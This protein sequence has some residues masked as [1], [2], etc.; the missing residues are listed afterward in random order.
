MIFNLIFNLVCFKNNYKN[1]S[2][3]FYY[4]KKQYYFLEKL[5]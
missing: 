5:Y 1:Q 4:K 3:I 2:V